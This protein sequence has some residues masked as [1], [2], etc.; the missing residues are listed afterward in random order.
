M[1]TNSTTTIALVGRTDALLAAH[2]D[3]IRIRTDRLFGAL[4]VAQWLAGIGL[5]LIVSPRSWAG[6]EWSVHLHV[7]VAVFLGG[8]IVAVPVL[9]AIATPGFAVTRHAVAVGQMLIGSLLIHLTGG[10]LETHFHVFGSLAFLAFY[11]DWKVLG[12]ATVI[13]AADHFL[14]GMF[15][16]QSI[17]GVLGGAEWR[18]LEHAG[19]VVF[20][21]IFLGASCIQA[22]SEMREI[23]VRHAE[24]ESSSRQLELQAEESRRLAAKNEH[25]AVEA[26]AAT[27]AKSEFL[28]TMSHELRTPMNAI[29]NYADLAI[30]RGAKSIALMADPAPLQ[31]QHR[32]AS[33]IRTAG[34]RLLSLINQLL[35]LSRIEAGR[36]EVHVEE[37]PGTEVISRVRKIADPLMEQNQNEFTSS[38]DPEIRFRTDVQK[39]EQCMINLVGNAAKFTHR[40]R[41][42]LQMTLVRPNTVIITVTDTGIGMTAEQ[43]ERLFV[44]FN[45]ADSS[46]TRQYGGSGLGLA[47]TKSILTLL[48]GTIGVTSE[49]HRGSTFTITIPMNLEQG[50]SPAIVA[51]PARASR[52]GPIGLDRRAPATSLR[53]S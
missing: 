2:N 39:L 45:Q 18:W 8:A 38:C 41:I 50:A 29:I 47:I 19:W 15:Y 5:S 14:R 3:R 37:A 33:E 31:Q 36:L 24:I 32:F 10:R 21:D 34:E 35:D 28:A 52:S 16:P 20:E 51:T 13:A 1:T 12:T 30:R 48:G 17:Y 23:A 44:P 22:Q 11:R 9:L 26:L 42:T 7:V 40:G 46:I 6:S 53:E 27:K 43:I 25:L 49:R 4:L